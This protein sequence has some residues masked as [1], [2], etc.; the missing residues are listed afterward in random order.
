MKK[1][2]ALVL[3]LVLAFSLVGCGYSEDDIDA[4]YKKGYDKGYDDATYEA[5]SNFKKDLQTE[6][7]R[8]YLDGIDYAS[9]NGYSYSNGNSYSFNYGDD[10]ESV[11]DYIRDNPHEFGLYTERDLELAYDSGLENAEW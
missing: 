10:V 1:L 4:A 8:G 7:S 3:A 5:K 11:L 9:K 2:I 6:Y